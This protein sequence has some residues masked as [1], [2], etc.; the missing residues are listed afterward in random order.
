MAGLN[1]SIFNLPSSQDEI[2]V[3]EQVIKISTRKIIAKSASKRD[4]FPGSDITFDFTLSG[5]QHW[6][7]SRSFVVIRDSIYIGRT[8]P[9]G[10]NANTPDQPNLIDDV[11]PAL[12]LQDNLFDGCQLTI[13]GFSLGSRTKLCPQI[14][15]VNKRVMKS[16]SWLDGVGSSASTWEADFDRRKNDISRFGVD[17]NS[18][19]RTVDACPGTLSLVAAVADNSVA[20]NRLATGIGSFF[21]EQL[22]P[23]DDILVGAALNRAYTI[24]TINTALLMDLTDNSHPV[25]AAAI[26]A[27]VSKGAP[28]SRSNRN[29]RIYV[30][31]LGVFN[32]GKALPP[33][34][35]ELILRPKPDTVYKQSALQTSVA[36]G[37]GIQ[38]GARDT[39]VLLT[40]TNLEYIVDD[41]V[42]YIAVVDNFAPVAAKMTY[43]LDLEETE[44]LPR[45]ISGGST[46]QENFTVSKSTYA[47]TV[48]LQ[49]KTAGRST[50]FPP[51]LFKVTGQHDE[52]LETLRLDYGGQSRPQPNAQPL[53]EQ[54]GNSH[55]DYTTYRYIESSVEDLAYYDTGGDQ[56]KEQW[57]KLGP[58]YHFQWRRIG[59]DIS[60]NV[61]VEVNYPNAFENVAGN[62]QENLLLFHHFKRVVEMT[63]E[64]GQVTQFL[65]QDA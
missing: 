31:P 18:A 46:V 36:E 33:A 57:R 59:D 4:G 27:K 21:N 51:S 17:N 48:A 53:F 39:G 28:T 3:P 12:N 30:P 61:D 14:S 58:M 19:V 15:A 6:L 62:T 49:S 65:A 47:L 45:K 54:S 11:A 32:Q 8:V 1:N 16:A 63:I 5:N 29:E 60:T 34:R 55:I 42:F 24:A 9:V 13:G 52:E 35:Y 20:A 64:A 40:N 50:L 2:R 56:T 37:V 25:Q 10:G 22:A 7:P 44:V 38:G 43:V 23:G 41:I 26:Y